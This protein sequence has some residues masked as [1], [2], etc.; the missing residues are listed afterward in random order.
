MRFTGWVPVLLL[1]GDLAKHCGRA[2]RKRLVFLLF[3]FVTFSF[4]EEVE[5][6]EKQQQLQEKKNTK[7]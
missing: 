5:K 6:R 7:N 2:L 4:F 1:A 3:G